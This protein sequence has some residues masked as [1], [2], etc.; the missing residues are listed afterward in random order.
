MVEH[1]FK[2]SQFD[3]LLESLYDTTHQGPTSLESA[4]GASALGGAQPVQLNHASPAYRP[5]VLSYYS[6]PCPLDQ[7][8]SIVGVVSTVFRNSD[9]FV[10]EEGWQPRSQ[11]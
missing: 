1:G 4:Y 8:I 9:S 5:P 11:N 7:T 3:F 10:E 2:L 6:F